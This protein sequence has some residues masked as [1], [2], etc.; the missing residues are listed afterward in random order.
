[1]EVKT[2]K[3]E[4]FEFMNEVMDLLKKYPEKDC[5]SNKLGRQLHDIRESPTYD[6]KEA[7]EIIIALRKISFDHEVFESTKDSLIFSIF[8]PGEDLLDYGSVED[9]LKLFMVMPPKVAEDYSSTLPALHEKIGELDYENL[10]DCFDLYWKKPEALQMF[11]ESSYPEYYKLL[12][13]MMKRV[14]N[15][16]NPNPRPTMVTCDS[17]L[18]LAIWNIK[19]MNYLLDK[20]LILKPDIGFVLGVCVHWKKN[21]KNYNSEIISVLL[22]VQP[23][24]IEYV[25]RNT[26][27]A[28]YLAQLA[29]RVLVYDERL[30]KKLYNY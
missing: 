29:H 3:E 5:L 12:S 23:K 6:P 17:M 10:V 26:V 1:M 11:S 21:L 9:Y 24:L 20:Y 2:K 16:Y 7:R 28:D 19:D 13:L 18:E 15:Y 14:V 25:L 22:E 4:V 8:W 27:S 30:E